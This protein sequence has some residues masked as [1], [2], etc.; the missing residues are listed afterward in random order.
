M[1]FLQFTICHMAVS[2]LSRPIGESSMMVPV[3]RVNWGASCLARQC[4]RLYFSRKSTSRLPQRGQV[5][6]FGQRRL[7]KYSRQLAGSEKYTMASWRVVGSAAMIYSRPF[8]SFCQLYYCPYEC[9][10]LR[11]PAGGPVSSG[12][13]GG[14]RGMVG[15]P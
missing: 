14:L 3:L 5:T 8:S 12:L 7:T 2:H 9:G 1:P 11:P 10:V 6:P 13:N 15:R 4:Q